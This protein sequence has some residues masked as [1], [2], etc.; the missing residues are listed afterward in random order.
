MTITAQLVE[1]ACARRPA[2]LY[3]ENGHVLNVFSGELL[4]DAGVAISGGK[5]AYV[6]PSRKMI[7]PGTERLDAGGGVLVP[8]YIDPHAHF[9]SLIPLS[10]LAETCFLLGT[11]AIVADT[12]VVIDH[13]GAAG[14]RFLKAAAD[15][16]PLCLYYTVPIVGQAPELG[17][18]GDVAGVKLSDAEIAEILAEER[19]VGTAEFLPWPHL[20]EARP[21]DQERLGYARG[22]GKLREGHNPGASYDKLQAVAAA[23]ITAC[24]E[25]LNAREALDRLRAGLYVMLRHGP[26]RADLPDLAP[27][28]LQEGVDRSRLMLTPDWIL[29]P[30]LVRNGHMDYLIKV[31]M[32]QGIPPVDAYRMATINPARYFRIEEERGSIAPG[33]FADILCLDDLSKPRPRWTMAA[34]RLVARDGRTVPGWLPEARGPEPELPPYSPPVRRARPEDFRVAVEGRTGH[35]RVWAISMVNRTITRPVELELPVKD[36]FVDLSGHREQVLKIAIPREEGGFAVAFLVG[37]GC[38]LSALASSLSS[39]PFPTLI[40]GGS[41]QDMATAYNHLIGMGGGLAAVERGEVVVELPTP[42]GGFISRLSVPELAERIEAFNGWAVS[43]G[44][45]VDNLFITHHFL[46]FPGVPFARMTPWGIYHLKD[47]VFLPAVAG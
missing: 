46:S 31:A 6:G 7:G 43:R 4:T 5:V 30:D 38:C 34:G 17:E 24:H 40:I 16:V 35:V 45:A 21:R 47:R 28:V 36:G 25:A 10:H 26:V 13:F 18:L 37:V 19:V 32:E 41:D 11:T 1:V 20:L 12:Q 3:I 2:D 23:G 14:F 9:D 29:P 8:G 33:R 22:L 15:R 39:D 42:D 27:L 44:S